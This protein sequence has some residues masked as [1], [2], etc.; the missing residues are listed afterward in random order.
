VPISALLEE[1]RCGSVRLSLRHDVDAG[2]WCAPRMA[3]ALAK[4]SSPGVFYFLHTAAYYGFVSPI[5]SAQFIRQPVLSGIVRAVVST[6]CE[7]G[8]HNDALHVFK[9]WHLDGCQALEQEVGW[10]REHGAKVASTSAHNSGYVYGGENFEL[11]RGLAAWGRDRL[12]DGTQLGVVSQET[13]GIAFEANYPLPSKKRP[14]ETELVHYH[15]P[16]AE[17]I[18]NQLWLENHFLN[19]PYFISAYDI[20]AWLTG[21]DRWFIADRRGDGLLK[22][23][24]TTEQVLSYLSSIENGATVVVNIH[25]DYFA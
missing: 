3:R 23:M 14:A 24:V 15:Q 18:R 4:N 16:H 13:L 19:N 11:F 17:P 2:V 25:P 9:T 12:Q 8:L 5:G 20:D 21:H 7:V 10:L 22:D 1:R 6:D